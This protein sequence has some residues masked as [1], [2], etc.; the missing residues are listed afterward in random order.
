[1]ADRATWTAQYASRAASPTSADECRPGCLRWPPAPARPGRAPAGEGD[2]LPGRPQAV[3][4]DGPDGVLQADDGGVGRLQLG[5]GQ[6]EAL[7]VE[8]GLQGGDGRPGAGHGAFQMA[9]Q[10]R[11]R[12]Q[13][14]DTGRAPQPP[15]DRFEAGGGVGRPARP[16]GQRAE[17]GR[18]RRPA[19]PPEGV[20][21][22][23]GRPA[24]QDCDDSTHGPET[25]RRPRPGGRGRRGGTPVVYVRGPGVLLLGQPR[26][27]LPGAES[28]LVRVRLE[29][30]RPK[31]VTSGPSR[32][33]CSA[34]GNT[35]RSPMAAALLGRRLDDAGVKADVSSAGL[36]FDGKA[37]HRPTA[38]P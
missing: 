30:R 26:S 20:R 12:G 27:A 34:P 9:G 22:G 23:A 10:F 17:G 18:R 1:M 19:A 4:G 14:A 31:P 15:V 36:L 11:I 33:S 29:V 32:S 28:G 5:A 7:G 37:G 13:N 24:A 16:G 38:W 3:G 8:V 35:C 2:D 25:R 6:E 21:R